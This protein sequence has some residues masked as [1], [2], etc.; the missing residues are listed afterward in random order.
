MCLPPPAPSADKG[1][2]ETL[3]LPGLERSMTTGSVAGGVGAL[4]V[5]SRL[6]GDANIS[7]QSLPA[8][9]S[10]SA[11]AARSAQDARLPLLGVDTPVAAVRA[12]ANNW[13][14]SQRSR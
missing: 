6:M 9:F 11:E 4:T 5:R 12:I 1:C 3:G 8:S 2:L 7:W 13:S 14:R 10:L